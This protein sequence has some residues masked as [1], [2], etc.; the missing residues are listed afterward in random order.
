MQQS[1][2][3]LYL[4][5]LDNIF[6]QEPLFFKEDS[7]IEGVPGVSAIV[8][9]DVP[10]AGYI[11]AF[12]YGLSLVEHPDWKLGRPE[13]CISVK[14]DNMSWA[15]VIAYMANSLRGDCPFTYGQTI[16][17]GQQVSEDSAM[18]AFLVFAPSILDKEDY[19]DIEIGAKYKLNI[20]GMYPVYASELDVYDELGLEAF[21]HHPGFDM[22]DV[23]RPL[24]SSAK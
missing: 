24:I 12:T 2:A 9:K 8:Y 23:T 10:E 13:L 19:L 4:R 15:R 11:T 18:D 3:N 22:Y 14:S 20:A 17:F 16:N 1:P 7:L 21:W 6:Q 5:H